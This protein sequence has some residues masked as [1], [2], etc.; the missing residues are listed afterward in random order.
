MIL[1]PVSFQ[2][3]MFLLKVRSANGCQLKQTYNP[4]S[5]HQEWLANVDVMRVMNFSR[6]PRFSVCI[7]EKLRRAWVRGY[8]QLCARVCIVRK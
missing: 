8:M 1:Q 6:L 7:T 5:L 2:R 4:R 3:C